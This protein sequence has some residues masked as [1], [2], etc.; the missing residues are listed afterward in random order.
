MSTTF[1]PESLD[2]YAIAQ[3]CWQTSD[4]SIFQG[5]IKGQDQ[6]VLI[7]IPNPSTP[8]R[9]RE[10]EARRDYRI[11]ESLRSK[12]VARHFAVETT[13]VGPIIVYR[14][15]GARPLA[16]FNRKTA[17]LADILEIAANVAAA[18]GDLHSESLVHTN[19]SVDNVWLCPATG[20]IRVSDFALS[21]CSGID[22]P[23]L[24][25]VQRR[26]PRFAAPEQ[27]GRTFQSVDQRSDVYSFG[28]ILFYL[29]TGRVPFEGSGATGTLN[30]QPNE[31]DVFVDELPHGIPSTLAQL[32]LKC[33]EK[34]N[35]RRYASA[36]GVGADVLECLSQLRSTGAINAF[37]LARHDIPTTFRIPRTLYGRE[38]ETTILRRFVRNREARPAVMLVAGSPG[39]GKTAFLSQLA[40]I[41][42]HEHGR[43]IAGKFDQYRRNVPYF[44]LAQAFRELV[45]QLL[46]EPQKNLATY[47][48]RLLVACEGNARLMLDLIPDL[49]LIIGP[50]P[51]VASLAPHEARNRFD[52][53]FRNVILALA[54]REQPLCLFMDDLQW[55]DSASLQVLVSVLAKLEG[56]RIIF[57]AAYRESELSDPLKLA[58][59]ALERSDIDLRPVVLKPLKVTDVQQFVRDTIKGSEEESLRLAEI[60]HSRTLGNPLHLTQMLHFLHDRELISFDYSAGKWVWDE[61]QIRSQAITDDVLDLIHLRLSGLPAQTQRLLAVAACLGSTFDI[62]TLASSLSHSDI[63]PELSACIRSDLIV[64]LDDNDAALLGTQVARESRFRFLHD[65]IQQAA[66]N[67]VEDSAK[68]SFRLEIGRRLLARLTPLEL[69]RPQIDILNNFNYARELITDRQECKTIAQLNLIAGSKARATLA[70]NDALTYLSTGISL[71]DEQAWLESPDTA[72][73]LHVNALECEYLT[74][75]FARAEALFLLLL[76]KATT[77]QAQAKIYLTKI[78]LDTSEARYEQAIESGIQ[79][80]RLFGIHYR[81]NPGLQHIGFE[82]L[83]ARI[84]MHGRRPQALLDAETLTDADGLAALKIL[85]ALFP[86]AYFLGPNLLM[87]SALKVVNYSLR[88]GI[89]HLSASGFVLYGLVLA[90][91][92]GKIKLGY[93]FGQ[94]AVELAERAH[95]PAVTCKVL[96]IFSEFIKY[97][98]DPLDQSLP[99]IERA[100]VLALQAGDHQYVNYSII[101][102]LSLEFSRGANLTTLLSYCAAH[103]GFVRQSKDTFTI[104]SMSIWR[105]CILALVGQTYTVSSLSNDSYDEDEAESAYTRMHNPTL[106][107]YQNTLRS[108]LCYLFGQHEKALKCSDRSGAVMASAPGQITVADHLLY[109]GLAAATMLTSGT[110]KRRHLRRIAQ[111]CLRQLRRFAASSSKNFLPY[112]ML[113]E[114][115]LVHAA[116]DPHRAIKLYNRVAELAEEQQFYHLVGIANERAAVCLLADGQRRTAAGYLGWARNAYL[117]WGASAKVAMMDREH[118]PLLKLA[119]TSLGEVSLSAISTAGPLPAKETFDVVGAAA[120]V[121]IAASEKRGDNVLGALM[122]RMRAQAGA[123]KAY[124]IAPA[125]GTYRIAAAALADGVE[126]DREAHAQADCFS[127]AI[128]NYVVH[129]GSDL[130]VDNPHEDPRFAQCKY[131]IRDQ[132]RAVMCSAIVKQSEL[133]GLIYLEHSKLIGAFDFDKLQWLRILG[134]EVGLAL[135]TDKLDRY[136]E[137]IRHFTPVPAAQEIDANPDNPNLAV[138]EKEVSVLFADLAG[139]TRMH[140][141]LG[142]READHLVNR[143]FSEFIEEIHLC[144]GTVIGIRGDELLVL[145]QDTQD[146]DHAFNAASAALAIAQV[147]AQ[148]NRVRSAGQPA[149]TVNMGINSGLAAVGLQPI[150]FGAEA[151]WRYDVTGTTVNVAAR[152]RELA[153]NGDILI[154][155]ATREPLGDR[156]CYKDTGEHSLKNVSAA[157]RVFQLLGGASENS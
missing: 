121:Q 7:K 11:S 153:R 79:A 4:A 18:L 33:L 63:V 127:S 48:E 47:R 146:G 102:Q 64:A 15:D 53:V 24:S 151:R 3:L 155:A 141:L 122:E 30:R 104:E 57:A 61:Q 46:A 91:R 144:H 94:L 21:Q 16:T 14:D 119:A 51:A 112:A 132:P 43:F 86:T 9:I 96:V 133:L 29:L 139:Y 45:H 19:L 78:L 114:A 147:A 125:A 137:Y 93:E 49:E 55:A 135:R 38:T 27:T 83:T 70:Y 76:E 116:A 66:F 17:K 136:R 5:C 1:L 110:P 34:N 109:R 40:E 68:K 108:Q 134:S 123:E 23:V 148:L 12:F 65:R 13:D 120:A 87:F 31:G 115:E 142:H 56:N 92:L 89:S 118:A 113:I 62:A 32:V 44:S 6:P 140:E 129:V 54:S 149:I 106:L 2:R 52:R 42:L 36:R 154:G 59:S 105:N 69:S 80:L 35:E 22:P 77:R 84:R 130:I 71:L 128:L 126:R 26:D 98:R 41:I 85:V 72:F 81:R 95:D 60:I 156:F 131:L 58:I 90:A 107:A 20:A 97:W 100:R 150:G 124:L 99:L 74:G 103:D 111:Q 82:L 88:H 145:F 37:R 28:V 25:Q 67:L 138:R 8:E 73:D 152:I 101:G 143:A 10:A 157:V 39:V 50:Q 117:R 75:S